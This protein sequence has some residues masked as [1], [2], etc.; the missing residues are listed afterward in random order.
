MSD[1]DGGSTVEPGGMPSGGYPPAGAYPPPGSYPPAGAYPP[2]GSYPPAGAYPPP[3]SYPPAGAY[4]PPPAPGVNDAY[5]AVAVPGGWT[6]SSPGRRLG[7]Y[8]L[9]VV[10]AIFTVFIGWFIWSLFIWRCGETPGMQ[11]MRMKTIKAD[12]GQPATWGTMAVREIVGK[13]IIMGVI[14]T[15]F[16]PATLVLDCM[17]LWDRRNQELWDKVAGTLV[18]DNR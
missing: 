12:T 5:G 8:L 7:Q 10:L 14:S 2:P 13:A 9:D 17:L 11:I 16:F 1:V 4:P 6:L 3:G 18:V 15:I